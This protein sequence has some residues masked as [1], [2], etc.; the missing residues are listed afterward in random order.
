M[1]NGLHIERKDYGHGI[2]FTWVVGSTNESTMTR[3]YVEINEADSA[4]HICFML[5]G[6]AYKILATLV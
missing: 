2:G 6:F 3:F 1:R 5:F 4:H